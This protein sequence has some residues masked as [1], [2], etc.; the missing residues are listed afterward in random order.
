MGSIDFAILAPVP[1]E[2]IEDGQKVT[3]EKG[4]VCFGSAKWELFRALDARRQ[5]RPVPVVLY[6]SHNEDLADWGYVVAWRGNYIGSVEDTDEK[7]AE[8]RGGHRPESTDKYRAKGDSATGWAVFWRV[9]DLILLPESERRELRAFQS[10]RT[11][12]DRELTAPRGP[13]VI[14]RPLWL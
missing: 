12:K 11:G 6:A 8:E 10:F 5:G 1:R 4:Y 3:Q 13:E 9:S 2:H 14:S 7:V